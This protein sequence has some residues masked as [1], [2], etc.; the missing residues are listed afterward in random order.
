MI[1]GWI[2]SRENYFSSQYD[3]T[4]SGTHPWALRSPS[5]EVQ[6]LSN[7][8]TTHLRQVPSSRMIVV[9]PLLLLYAFMACTGI[10]LSLQAFP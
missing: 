3:K 6:W 2:P 9:I 8:L 1:W 4:S 5:P 10:T 7:K